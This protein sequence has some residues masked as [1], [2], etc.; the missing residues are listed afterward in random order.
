MMI[1]T[2]KSTLTLKHE[3]DFHRE[4]PDYRPRLKAWFYDE[5]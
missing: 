2:L 1:F 5:E 3:E 4:N